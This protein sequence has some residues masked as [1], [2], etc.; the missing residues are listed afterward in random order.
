MNVNTGDEMQVLA[1]QFN[2]MGVALKESYS[3]L[4][5]KVI[6]RTEKERQR[7]EQ[8]RTINEVSRKISSIVNLD[9]LLAYVGNLLQADVPF[10]QCEYI[11]V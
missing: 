2:S 4:E 1:E 8:L 11:P 6:E 3:N 7:A 9:E 5:Q 10:P